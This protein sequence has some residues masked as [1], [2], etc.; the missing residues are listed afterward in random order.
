MW[1]FGQIG[2]Y[3]STAILV[4]A[5]RSIEYAGLSGSKATGGAFGTHVAR[6]VP[7][8]KSPGTC[9]L[10]ACVRDRTHKRECAV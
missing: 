9:L 3:T 1:V 4:G 5:G 6:A 8:W 2:S 7:G 10:R